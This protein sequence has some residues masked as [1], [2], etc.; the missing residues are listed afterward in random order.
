MNREDFVNRIIP[1]FGNVVTSLLLLVSI[2]AFV[3]IEAV[4]TDVFFRF[5]HNEPKD[6]FFL[7]VVIALIL[8][9]SLV[10]ARQIAKSMPKTAG[11]NI[12]LFKEKMSKETTKRLNRLAGIITLVI[13]LPGFVM[14][15]NDALQYSFA[16]GPLDA[17][18]VIA[19]ELFFGVVFVAFVFTRWTIRDIISGK[20][21]EVLKM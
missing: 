17:F 2:I 6:F 18:R 5:G 11:I 14:I 21:P 1:A 15:G 12:R 9:V 4:A 10:L 19:F 13:A 3:C 20:F 16:P 7:I 8:W